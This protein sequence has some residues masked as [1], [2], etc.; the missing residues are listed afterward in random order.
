M[1][2]DV[3]L[4]TDQV[5]TSSF[6]STLAAT[7]IFEQASFHLQ[8]ALAGGVDEVMEELGTVQLSGDDSRLVPEPA[9]QSSKT[10]AE[11]D[12]KAYPKP[13]LGRDPPPVIPWTG[14]RGKAK[15][16]IKW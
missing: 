1:P 5:P 11:Y 13:M 10:S 7:D 2:I 4:A 16:A 9:E 14:T 3:E 8:E 6:N 15:T 12:R